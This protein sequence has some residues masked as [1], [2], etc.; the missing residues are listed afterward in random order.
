MALNV[1]RLCNLVG[2]Y[3]CFRRTY[4]LPLQAKYEQCWENGGYAE[5]VGKQTNQLYNL[6]SMQPYKKSVFN[7]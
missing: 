6:T 5:V 3:K 4:C 2:T 7:P 1:M